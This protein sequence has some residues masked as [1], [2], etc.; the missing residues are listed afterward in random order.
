[1]SADSRVRFYRP[2]GGLTT[3]VLQAVLG[4]VAAELT[5]MPSR[6]RITAWTDMERLVVYDW[7]W[8]IHLKAADNPVHLRARPDAILG[9]EATAA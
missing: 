7:A 2:Q 8:R 5:D 3:G 6:D 9:E 4:L 1:V